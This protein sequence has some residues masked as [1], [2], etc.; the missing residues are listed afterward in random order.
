MD[1]GHVWQYWADKRMACGAIPPART[2]SSATPVPFLPR[3]EEVF[4]CRVCVLK[5]QTDRACDI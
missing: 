5:M 3:R 2:A 4:C 1:A